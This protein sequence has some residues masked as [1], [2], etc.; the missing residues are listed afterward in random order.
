MIHC[1][2]LRAIAEPDVA[3]EADCEGAEGFDSKGISCSMKARTIWHLGRHIP[4]PLSKAA[5]QPL[6]S[7]K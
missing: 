3:D 4:K 5:G 6:A 7:T 2:H 1:E